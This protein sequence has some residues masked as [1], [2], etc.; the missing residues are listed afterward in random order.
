VSFK[1][2]QDARTKE[3]KRVMALICPKC[4]SGVFKPHP[5]S[6]T[7]PWRYTLK[8]PVCGFCR[9]ELPK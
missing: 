2:D 4:H 9:E 1:Y 6:D 5:Q 8:C 3:D 7:R